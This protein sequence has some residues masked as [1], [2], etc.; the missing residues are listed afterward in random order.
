MGMKKELY[1]TKENAVQKSDEWESTRKLFKNHKPFQF[2]PKSSALLILDM[3]N[4]F[5]SKISHA[6]VPSAPNI[7]PNI[8]NLLNYYSLHELP[9]VFTRHVSDISTHD[10]MK[11]WWRDLIQ[12]NEEK[13]RIISDLDTNGE[14]I[15][16]KHQYSAFY[17][18]NLD[19][20][21]Q[22]KGVTQLVITGVLT[23][24]CCESTT[25]DA[26][27]RGY[28][29]F[30]PFDATASYNESLHVGSI[31]AISHGFGICLATQT[32]LDQEK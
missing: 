31:R 30:L 27:M 26:F 9:I 2:T 24:L 12:D 3:Q 29:V 1:F 25:R 8:Q 15:I 4:F 14:K 13:S 20:I 21:L 7:V 18:T 5:L 16:I 17:N 32:L 11:T 23:H 6:F 22:K 10:M 19:E 28:Q